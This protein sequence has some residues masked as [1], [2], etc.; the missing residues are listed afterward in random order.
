VNLSRN[1]NNIAFY[2]N[3]ENQSKEFFNDILRKVKIENFVNT[4][5]EKSQTGLGELGNSISGGQKQRIGIARALYKNPEI[6]IFDEATSALDLNTES[7]IIKTIFELP[8]HITTIIISHKRKL[9]DQ[10]DY[11]YEIKDNKIKII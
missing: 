2:S 4:L 5:P 7:Q 8:N 9:L 6:I 1:N 10:C 3:Q 11:I